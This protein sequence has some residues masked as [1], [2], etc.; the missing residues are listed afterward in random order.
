M[1]IIKDSINNCRAFFE[2]ERTKEINFRLDALFKLKALIKEN[3]QKI[4]NAL[5]KDL[6]KSEFESFITEIAPVYEEINLHIKSLKKWAKSKNVKTNL[7]LLPSKSKIIPTPYGVVLIISPWNYPFNLTIMPLIGA[8]SAGN[9]SI[10]KPSEYSSETSKIIEEIFDKNFDKGFISVING[11]ATQSK[12]LLAEK[13]DYIFFTGSTSIGKVVMQAASKNLTPV[14]LELGGKS[15]CIVEKSTN[16]KI[17]AKRIVWGKFLNAGQTCVAPDYL[18]VEESIKDK[19]VE[20]L[21]ESIKIEFSDNPIKSENYSRIINDK[22]FDR[23]IALMKNKKIL[24]GGRSEKESLYIEP[25]IIDLTDINDSIMKEE[26]FGPILPVISIKS[27]DEAVSIVKNLSSPL[28]LYI[29]SNNKKLI[30]KIVS[31]CNSGGVCINDTIVHLANPNLPFGGIGES[32]I[33]SYHGKKSFDT[34]THYRAILSS[35]TKIDIPIKYPP[36]KR[37]K[38]KLIKALYK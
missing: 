34:F 33:G 4:I 37:W 27:I 5:Y 22:H 20:H 14:T 31:K 17:A 9:C 35:P 12:A 23:L 19:L 24:Y 10:I 6:K 26:I 36:Y 13:F 28:A 16:L 1:N 7:P 8:M 3:E 30:N 25:T 38:L 2:T 18:L 32:G 15:P 21:I 11:D 29:F